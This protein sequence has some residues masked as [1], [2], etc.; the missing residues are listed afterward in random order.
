[1]DLCIN[2]KKYVNPGAD[3][4]SVPECTHSE[5]LSPVD[6]FPIQVFDG[7]TSMLR[8]REDKCKGVW[9]EQREKKESRLLKLFGIFS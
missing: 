5:K 7:E 8:F 6:G 2:C 4:W 1:M 3:D 9:F